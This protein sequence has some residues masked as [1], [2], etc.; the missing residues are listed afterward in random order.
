MADKTIA[1]LG[2]SIDVASGRRDISSLRF[3]QE[4]PRVY[5]VTHGQAGFESKPPEEQQE[6]I[7]LALRN[8]PSVKNLQADIRRHGGLMEPILI[9]HDT[10]EVIEGNSRLA[11]YRLLHEDEGNG[12]WAKIDCDIV[13]RL[14]DEQQTAYLNQIHIKGKTK[15]TA[16][17]KAN[18]AY[19]SQKKGYSY[20][21]MVDL[22]GET[23]P[24]IR[25]RVKV[26]EAMLENEDG[27]QSNFSYY[28][29]I[30]RNQKIKSE[31]DKIARIKRPKIAAVE[32]LSRYP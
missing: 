9:R 26:I 4:N 15:W 7:F 20:S 31:I 29:V 11:V 14:T 28:D 16:Y 13:S 22:F 30:V 18:F 3:L 19:V 5:T 8:E 32:H 1:I 25:T 10:N 21:D 12:R 24:T 27:E 17:E 23:E 2:E 6:E